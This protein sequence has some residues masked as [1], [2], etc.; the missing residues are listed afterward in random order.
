[1]IHCH[2]LHHAAGGMAQQ[3][4]YTDYKPAYAPPSNKANKPE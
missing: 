4:V 2:E 3:L 1:M